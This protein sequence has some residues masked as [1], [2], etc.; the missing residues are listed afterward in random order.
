MSLML[1]MLSPVLMVM[2]KMKTQSAH[3]FMEALVADSLR[4][5]VLRYSLFGFFDAK[6]GEVPLGCGNLQG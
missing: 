6:G 5:L 3:L 1:M 2:A 4:T